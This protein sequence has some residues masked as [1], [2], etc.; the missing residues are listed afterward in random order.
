MEDTLDR[1]HDPRLGHI[2]DRT[3]SGAPDVLRWPAT[4]DRLRTPLIRRGSSLVPATW[5][6]ALELI[7]RRTTSIRDAFTAQAVAFCASDR[8]SLEDAYTLSVVALAGVGTPHLRTAGGTTA[9]EALMESFGADGAPGSPRDVDGADAIFL[10]GG[11]LEDT[12][13][14]L[15][16]RILER[17]HGPRPP[18]LVVAGPRPALGKAGLHVPLR[19]GGGPALLDGLLHLILSADR[20]DHAFLRLHTTGFDALREAVRPWTPARSEAATGVPAGR[21][22]E[23]AAILGAAER[24]VSVVLP[25]ADAAVPVNNLH[26][27]RG[28]I[29]RP[30]C[31]V[32]HQGGHPLAAHLRETGCD[33]ALPAFRNRDNPAHVADLA[34]VWNVEPWRI[35]TWARPAPLSGILE[36]VERGSVRMLWVSGADLGA[37]RTRRSLFLVVS[38]ASLTETAARA[39]VVLPSALRHEKTGTYVRDDRSVRLAVKEVDPPGEARPE[40]DVYVDFARRMG[41]R[42]RDGGRLIPWSDPEGAFE[43]WKACSKGWPCD[44]SGLSY[45]RLRGGAAVPWPCTEESPD[46]TERLYADGVFPTEAGRGQTYGHDLATGAPVSPEAYRAANPAGRAIL[47]AADRVPPEL[48]RRRE[49]PAARV[50]P[51]VGRPRTRVAD[52][53]LLLEASERRLMEAAAEFRERYRSDADLVEGCLQVERWSR[54]HLS[55]LAPFA[56]RYG[57]RRRASSR[58]PKLKGGDPVRDLHEVGVRAYASK[59][60]GVA[61]LQAARAMGDRSFEATLERIAA[62]GERQ[63][64]W[65]LGALRQVAPQA[66]A[67]PV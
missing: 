30:G 23:A 12:E 31:T 34:R 8:L 9:S 11:G 65:I 50:R 1:V 29:G 24:L 27:V 26:L 60:A 56:A 40:M 28:M 59:T 19:P 53:L 41:F 14:Q 20:I 38:D 15:R 35:P 2:P 7:V 58:S 62:E 33:G 22:R 64:G 46:G 51:V 13:P 63:I 57:V 45:G 16:A 5:D 25:G 66:L 61:L 4:T 47:R 42:D 6:E 37:V 10:V 3:D 52:V 36:H 43:A 18:R 17:L 55:D 49:E 32:F 54:E 39:D 21:L 44:V 48:R 67:V